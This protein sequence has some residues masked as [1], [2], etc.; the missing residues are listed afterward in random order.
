MKYDYFLMILYTQKVLSIP[1][2]HGIRIWWPSIDLYSAGLWIRFF[3]DPAVF[4]N[5][6]PD[7]ALKNC[8]VAFLNW[9]KNYT[10]RIVVIHPP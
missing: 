8:L 10:W 9:V 6:D 5:A 2:P 1:D 4:V 3:A 7:P